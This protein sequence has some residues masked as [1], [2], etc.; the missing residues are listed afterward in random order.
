M[1]KLPP[2]L[3]RFLCW[4]GFHDFRVVNVTFGFGTDGVE[5]DECRRCGITR[6]RK[7]WYGS[8]DSIKKTWRRHWEI[9]RFQ[10]R[11]SLSKSNRSW[12]IYRRWA[13]GSKCNFPGKS[14]EADLD[15]VPVLILLTASK[16][17]HIFSGCTSDLLRSIGN[18]GA[19]LT[20]FLRSAH[21]FNPDTWTSISV[22]FL[23]LLWFLL[24]A[25]SLRFI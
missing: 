19:Y 15:Q 11:P 25:I 10:F 13:S 20:L 21:N 17:R 1:V 16:H 4:L 14:P 9:T 18:T 2:L 23:N 8:N 12:V 7:A 3:G 22:G 6:I 5:K 24:W